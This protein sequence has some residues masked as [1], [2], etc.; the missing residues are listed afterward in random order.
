V[1]EEMETLKLYLELENLRLGNRFTYEI[2]IDPSIHLYDEGIPP[3]L[4]QPFVENAIWHGISHLPANGHISLS[5]EKKEEHMVVTVK[6]NGIGRKRASELQ[7]PLHGHHRSRGIKNTEE[8]LEVM[9]IKRKATGRI[10]IIDLLNESEEAAG[11]KVILH[12]PLEPVY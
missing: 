7:K 6:D 5:L 10:E 8:R 3:L 2:K 4:I 1:E 11:T 12:L 9:D